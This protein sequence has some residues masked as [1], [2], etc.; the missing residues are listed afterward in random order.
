L[1]RAQA[2]EAVTAGE[3]IALPALQWSREEGRAAPR[4]LHAT[5]AKRGAR[6]PPSSLT[7]R[8]EGRPRPAL[9]TQQSQR[10]KPK[11]IRPGKKSPGPSKRFYPVS[12]AASRPFLELSRRAMLLEAVPTVYRAPLGRLERHFAVLATVRAFR[13]MHLSGA[14]EAPTPVSVSVSHILTLYFFYDIALENHVRCGRPIPRPA[15]TETS[16]SMVCLKVYNFSSI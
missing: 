3:L 7:N 6:A 14:T 9:F 10:N 15:L 1:V 13:G 8:K 11:N 16:S 2:S 4:P 5:T 12:R